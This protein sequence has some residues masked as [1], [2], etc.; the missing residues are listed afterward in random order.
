MQCPKDGNSL[1]VIDVRGINIDKCH[2]CDGLW[3]DHGELKAICDMDLSE[4]EEELEEKYGNPTVELG[5]V[6]GYMRCP[7]CGEEGRLTRHHVSYFH[8]P[9]QVDRCQQCHGMWLDDQELD[10]LL[11][12]KQ[13]MDQKLSNNRFVALCRSLVRRFSG[14]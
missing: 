3:L 14:S 6:S 4:I 5:E 8:V 12:D 1:Q 13:Q 10:A 11:D 9:V 2:Q 7:S